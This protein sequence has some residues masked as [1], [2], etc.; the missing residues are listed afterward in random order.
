MTGSRIPDSDRSRA[1]LIGTH[2]C[3]DE[4]LPPVPQIHDNLGGLLDALCDRQVGFFL[5]EHCELVEQ[6]SREDALEAVA[7]NG[8]DARDTFLVYYGGHAVLDDQRGDSLLLSVAESDRTSWSF[9][10]IDDLEQAIKESPAK[11]RI[12]ILDCCYSGSATATRLGAADE[13]ELLASQ[14]NMAGVYILASSAANQRS[15]APEG[16]TYTTFT[17]ALIK[18]LLVGIPDGHEYIE[19]HRLYQHL[20]LALA[21]PNPKPAQQNTGE[22]A[23]LAIVRN[24]AYRPATG[25]SGG[26]EAVYLS[27]LEEA[28]GDSLDLEARIDAVDLIARRAQTDDAFRRVLRMIT[29]APEAPVLLR[30]NVALRLDLLGD[31]AGAINGLELVVGNGGG[32]DALERLRELLT[33]GEFAEEWPKLPVEDEETAVRP[34][35]LDRLSDAHLWGRLMAMV[36]GAT[37]MPLEAMLD[38]INE[39]VSLHES[40]AARLI[41]EGLLRAASLDQRGRVQVEGLLNELPIRD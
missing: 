8:R 19:M 16:E 36:L 3:A 29:E 22:A 9:L 39:L 26:Q 27:Y 1:V 25:R 41:L 33:V 34:V 12:L 15:L 37:K 28:V 4:N 5:H 17:G 7:R 2:T 30:I 6:P 20:R 32:A 14:A 10:R 24:R 11:F 40:K 23:N 38:A 31:E 18:L 13:S 35:R 21:G